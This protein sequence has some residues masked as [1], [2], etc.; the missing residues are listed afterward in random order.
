MDALPQPPRKARVPWGTPKPLCACG[1]E[2]RVPRHSQKYLRGHKHRARR[3]SCACGCG[4]QFRPRRIRGGWQRYATLA[5]VPSS[6]RAEVCRRGRRTYAYRCRARRFDAE[7]KQLQGRTLTR[8]DLYAIF[9]RI[10][11]RA[12]NSGFNAGKHG[13]T[14]VVPLLEDVA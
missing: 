2:G 11:R 1:C 9:A 4:A 5:C 12:Y 13:R 8:E 14:P 7:I 3:V 10:E 6:L